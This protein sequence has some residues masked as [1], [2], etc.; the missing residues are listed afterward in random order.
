MPFAEQDPDQW[1]SN[2]IDEAEALLRSAV[3]LG[4][5]GRYQLEGALQSAH[6]NRRRTGRAN[7]AEVVQLYLCFVKRKSPGRSRGIPHQPV[8]IFAWPLCL[9]SACFIR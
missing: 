9:I 3:A 7:W 5:T 2:M 1:D 6:V 8:G 4:S